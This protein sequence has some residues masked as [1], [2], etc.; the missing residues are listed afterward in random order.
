MPRHGAFVLIVSLLALAGLPGAAEAHRLKV[1][2]T[3]VGETIQGKA[4][5]VGG[6]PAVN[7]SATLRDHDEEIVTEGS[8]DAEGRFSLIAPVK[9]DLTVVVDALDGHVARFDIAAA[10]LPDTLPTEDADGRA[11]APAP[12]AAASAPASGDPPASTGADELATVVARQIEPLAEQLD[13]LEHSIRLHD[14]LG[15]VGYIVGIFGLFAFLRSRRG[16]ARKGQ[17]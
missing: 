14:V 7:V 2:A 10:R 3:V 11:P 9:A 12:D 6:G 13:S 4:Y 5:F 17:A 15:G 1:F 8:T 16:A